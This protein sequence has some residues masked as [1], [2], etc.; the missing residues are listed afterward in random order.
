MRGGG[1]A[2]ARCAPIARALPRVDRARASTTAR[3]LAR[4][5]PPWRAPVALESLG[6]RRARGLVGTAA[7][8]AGRVVA[9]AS[10]DAEEDDVDRVVDANDFESEDA[11]EGAVRA[12][13]E[14]V[15]GAR[16][17]ADVD[18]LLSS[19]RT[20]TT[21]GGDW[22][23]FVIFLARLQA[24]G[25]S[26][27]NA[28]EIVVAAG[29][30]KTPEW[31]RGVSG[32]GDDAA[33]GADSESEFESDEEDLTPS[34]PGE[35]KRLALS[36]ARDRPDLFSRLPESLVY[37]LI[38]WPLPRRL[39]NRKLNAG[40]QRLRASMSMDVSHLRGKCSACDKLQDRQENPAL[41]LSD[42]L[43][44][45][46]VLND[47][48]DPDEFADLPSKELASDCV[49]RLLRLAESPKPPPEEMP[50]DTSK[51]S[52][53]KSS[54]GR[55]S[56]DDRPPR[57]DDRGRG[58][59]RGDSF[60][61]QRRDDWGRGGGSYERRDDRAPRFERRDDRGGY[62][63]RRDDGPP[64]FERRDRDDRR[65]E[66]G[67]RFDDRR[68]D[69]RFG[70][71]GGRGRGGYEGRGGRGGRGRGFDDDRRQSFD[72]FDDRPPRFERRDGGGRGGDFGGR[73][74]DRGGRGGGRFE[75]EAIA[76]A[77]AVADAFGDRGGGRFGDRDGVA[78]A[79]VS[80]TAAAVASATGT[81]VAVVDVSATAAVA[82][83]AILSA[84]ATTSTIAHHGALSTIGEARTGAN[85]A[86]VSTIAAPSEIPSA[87]A[88]VSTTT[89]VLATTTK[90]TAPVR[91]VALSTT[92]TVVRHRETIVAALSTTVDDRRLAI[93]ANAVPRT[94]FKSGVKTPATTSIAAAGDRA[95]T[96]LKVS[97][98]RIRS[99][100][101]HASA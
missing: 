25:Y 52:T 73:F 30:S 40:L 94:T 80:A 34:D 90:A 57:Y 7:A 47:I 76:S 81:A 70:D 98:I 69:D 14:A 58:R 75:I 86:V 59:G 54:T 43:R 4:V 42:L 28:D 33:A 72:R 1:G 16:V 48:D 66:F 22:A 95:I 18:E 65:E 77:V 8:R 100:F 85:S 96:S 92:T 50:I 10:D 27:V 5:A 45:L 68:S 36:F 99:T 35:I 82:V 6:A 53:A 79:D 87:L 93:P 71:R 63:R 21:W 26:G 51:V 67:S 15:V 78:V 62:E 83:D 61:G 20:T 37:Q 23:E 12:A 84:T 38:D 13:D 11:D 32:G 46:L 31:A 9:S 29:D 2:S 49:R 89:P 60:R 101:F 56:F 24:L 39:N 88:S 91:S 17:D 74:D 44:V 97:F 3:A 55:R 64:R 19:V 41:Q